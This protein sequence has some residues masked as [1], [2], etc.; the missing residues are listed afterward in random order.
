MFSIW[1]DFYI[2]T[3]E[4]PGFS[5]IEIPFF[6][7]VCVLCVCM[8]SSRSYS[9]FCSA[10]PVPVSV[11]RTFAFSRGESLAG[12]PGNVHGSNSI[13]KN[14]LN[15]YGYMNV[16]E[17]IPHTHGNLF[18]NN[19]FRKSVTSFYCVLMIIYGIQMN[20]LPSKKTR[21]EAGPTLKFG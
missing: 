10:L 2:V 15:S 5:S 19:F 11:S 17:L 7:P 16:L 14:G 4:L 1:V 13:M 9:R 3:I 12:S 21:H 6:F 18:R 8:L 20:G